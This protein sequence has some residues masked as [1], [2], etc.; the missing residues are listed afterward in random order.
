MASLFEFSRS[1]LKRAPERDS[2]HDLALAWRAN[3][4]DAR[5]LSMEGASAILIAQDISLAEA[6]AILSH[7]DRLF[8]K[9]SESHTPWVTSA[10]YAGDGTRINV[11]LHE[12]HGLPPYL[13]LSMQ[14][15]A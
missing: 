8:T 7:L 12:T 5:L 1:Y 11:E 9:A 13:Q 14:L 10:S 15:A 4:F 3:G 6:D 2:L